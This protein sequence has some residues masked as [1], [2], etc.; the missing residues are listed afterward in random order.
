MFLDVPPLFW[1]L[2]EELKSPYSFQRQ[3][4]GLPPIIH[5]VKISN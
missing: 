4:R 1:D 3:N 2:A 5:R